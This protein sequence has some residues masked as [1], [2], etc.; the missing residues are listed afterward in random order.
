MADWQICQITLK[1]CHTMVSAGNKP[2]V[3][4]MLI[5]PP[6]PHTILVIVFPGFLLLDAAG[7]LQVFAMAP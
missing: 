7:P 2:I 1:N 3:A 4:L 5:K 6:A